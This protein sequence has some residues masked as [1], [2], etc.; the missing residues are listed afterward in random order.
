[1]LGEALFILG[2][3]RQQQFL[4]IIFDN[5][6][7]QRPNRLI[8]IKLHGMFLYLNLLV[9]YKILT[10]VV[11]NKNIYLFFVDIVFIF[12]ATCEVSPSRWRLLPEI[13]RCFSQF[14][15]VTDNGFLELPAI[16]FMLLYHLI[17]SLLCEIILG[18]TG[19]KISSLSFS[20]RCVRTFRIRL[21][22]T[23]EFLSFLHLEIVMVFC[24]VNSHLFS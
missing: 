14:P 24:S 1:M 8:K 15:I 11:L 5:K 6:E 12:S 9:V 18:C 2:P 13:R 16:V 19:K 3:L 21:T 10:H 23:F 17:A 4:F 20:V 7:K 22:T